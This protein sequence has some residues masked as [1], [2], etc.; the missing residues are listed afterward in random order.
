MNGD[1]RIPMIL[2]MNV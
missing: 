1:D 2:I